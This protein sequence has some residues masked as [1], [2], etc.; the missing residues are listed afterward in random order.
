MLGIKSNLGSG[1]Q[2]FILLQGDLISI[3]QRP[4]STIIGLSLNTDSIMMFEVKKPVP[5][6]IA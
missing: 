3:Y 1:H 6:Q 2:Q 5:L 4:S